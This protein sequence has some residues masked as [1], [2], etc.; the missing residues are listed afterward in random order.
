LGLRLPLD[1]LPWIAPRD[2][3]P[4]HVPDPFQQRGVLH[5]GGVALANKAVKVPVAP[6]LETGKSAVE[7]I[8]TALCV[9]AREGKLYVFFPPLAAIEDWIDLVAAVES[10][11]AELNLRVAIEGYTPPFD[12]RIKRFAVTPDPGVIEVN[13]HPAS[14]WDEL[15]ANTRVLY[16]QA[17]LT[18]L[19]TEKFM[20]DGRHTGTGGG[21]HVTIG[22]S[23]PSDSPLLR[24]PDLLRSLI[25]YWQNH[26]A[27]SYLFSRTVHRS[28]QPGAAR[29]RSAQRQPLRT[30]N[31]FPA[32]ADAQPTR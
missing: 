12:P 4:L 18:R 21:N 17:R 6:K 14:N 5:E 3:E 7:I 9:Q 19:G 22:G 2:I 30:G 32:D 25:S 15:S 11:A 1:S 8:H 28:H 31:R 29:G 24:R 13:I 26:P 23:T 27:L 10:V 20:I 16:E